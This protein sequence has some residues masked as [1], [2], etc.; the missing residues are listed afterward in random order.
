MRCT[1]N[2][3]PQL[4]EDICV[5]ELI[6]PA[7]F[8]FP[9]QADIMDQYERRSLYRKQFRKWNSMFLDHGTFQD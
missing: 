8:G 5:K 1:C 4:L 3:Q 9:G 2:G 7:K 6:V